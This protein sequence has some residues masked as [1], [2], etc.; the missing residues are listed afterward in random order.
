MP[1]LAY[2]LIHNRSCSNELSEGVVYPSRMALG[3]H[4]GLV[5]LTA[6]A[7]VWFSPR[8]SSLL[9]LFSDLELDHFWE[10]L[11][12]GLYWLVLAG[13]GILGCRQWASQPIY[14]LEIRDDYRQISLLNANGK[15]LSVKVVIGWRLLPYWIQLK[16]Y[17]N[18]KGLIQ[19][20]PTSLL[21]WP[22]ST[23]AETQRKLRI[24]SQAEL[25]RSE[26]DQ[27]QG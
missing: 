9:F 3:V 13:V 15:P 4:C 8:M 27:A 21:L 14:K 1:T 20:V 24:A 18:E 22:D 10:L 2:K 5:I 25:S 17:T 12:R 23:G 19:R 26:S 11:E 6:F 7:L 16:I